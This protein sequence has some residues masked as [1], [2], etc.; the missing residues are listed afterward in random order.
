[1]GR[2]YTRHQMSLSVRERVRATDQQNDLNR[3]RDVR[4]EFVPSLGVRRPIALGEA[5]MRSL[6]RSLGRGLRAELGSAAKNYEVIDPGEWCLVLIE[7][8]KMI[9]HLR[10]AKHRNPPQNM[11]RLAGALQD[12]FEARKL[13][14]T[15]GELHMPLGQTQPFSRRA[16]MSTIGVA[17]DGWR[18]HK[19]AY[20]VRTGSEH[21][22]LNSKD[23]VEERELCARAISRC[24]GFGEEEAFD[25]LSATPRINVLRQ[26]RGAAIPDHEY[27]RIEAVLD[28][29]MPDMVPVSD[30][31]IS[32]QYDRRSQPLVATVPRAVHNLA[33]LVA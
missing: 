4:G 3:G 10:R 16:V 31:V 20:P 29:L 30:P 17:P 27:R 14:R 11:M 6:H 21:D 28:T 9:E 2:R 23:I 15:A 12:V 5:A 19:A 8:G 1:M 33:E 7:Q 25:S 22:L 32:V 24:I 13:E 18:G 26:K